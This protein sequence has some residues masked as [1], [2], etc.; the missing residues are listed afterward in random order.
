MTQRKQPGRSP[1]QKKIPSKKFGNM[2]FVLPVR[3][4]QK[5]VSLLASRFAEEMLSA[6]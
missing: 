1:L 6:T 2:T 4:Q 3:E 5:D